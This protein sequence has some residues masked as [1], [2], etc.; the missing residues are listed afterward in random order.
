MTVSAAV[1]LQI[2]LCTVAAAL[3]LCFSR[4]RNPLVLGLAFGAIHLALLGVIAILASCVDGLLWLGA[5][6]LD[7]P[8][9]L[10]F[11]RLEGVFSMKVFFLVIGTA[12]YVLTGTVIGFA[13]YIVRRYRA[14]AMAVVVGF[15]LLLSVGAD[16]AGPMT[17]SEM[18]RRAWEGHLSREEDMLPGISRLWDGVDLKQAFYSGCVF[19]DTM[20]G[21]VNDDAAEYAHWYAYQRDYLELLIE[22]APPPWDREMLRRVVF[23]LGVVCHGAA[24]VPWHFDQGP[25]KSIMT[26]AQEYDGIH[27]FLDHVGEVYSQVLFDLDG[28]EV[29]GHFY[30]P[31]SD[32]FAVFQ[33]GGVKV[34][35]DDIRR[36]GARQEGEWRRAALLSPIAYPVFQ[37]RWPWSRA[38]FEDYYYG[39]M[40]HGSA[41][42]AVCLRYCYARLNGWHLYQNV[43][44]KNILYSNEGPHAPFRDK[45]IVIEAGVEK[46]ECGATLTVG[47]LGGSERQADLRIDVG[48][49]ADAGAVHTAELWLHP[50]GPISGD[51][52]SFVATSVD[53]ADSVI[54]PG[55]L[56][57]NGWVVFE[58]TPLVRSWVEQ[59]EQNRG[60][61][62]KAV[63]EAEPVEFHSSDAMRARP[64]GYGGNVMAYRPVL[65]VR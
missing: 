2:V 53:Q 61:R 11:H 26:L 60:V 6:I 31:A 41:L 12:Q 32:A 46:E 40:V 1:A 4:K 35:L 22:K 51:A 57:Q 49:I 45:T 48:D 50:A 29:R 63:D 65:V 38:H 3:F 33:R 39:G 37:W 55:H 59:P 43:H 42:T 27:H 36:G 5:S 13:A 64:D 30:C 52:L 8:S 16:A 25:D 28:V 14:V 23:F 18:G 47:K 58:V 34:T 10:L 17:H 44:V 15:F 54:F 56:H 21:G 19:P 9:V 62:V 24:D 7:I 20:Q